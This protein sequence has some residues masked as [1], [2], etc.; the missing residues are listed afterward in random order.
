MNLGKGVNELS[1]ASTVDAI[2][3]GGLATRQH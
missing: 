3:L 2:G 1:C